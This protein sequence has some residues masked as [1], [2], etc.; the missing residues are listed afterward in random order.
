MQ[1]TWTIYCFMCLSCQS[2]AIT[3]LQKNVSMTVSIVGI[4]DKPNSLQTQE[5]YPSRCKLRSYPTHSSLSI[6]TSKQI[7]LTTIPTK[8]TITHRHTHVKSGH[9]DNHR[10]RHTIMPRLSILTKCRS[11]YILWRCIGVNDSI[12]VGLATTLHP[13]H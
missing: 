6:P 3:Q 13:L 12:S 7:K 4:F 10:T 2:C 8:N 9:V 11:C 1:E 5:T